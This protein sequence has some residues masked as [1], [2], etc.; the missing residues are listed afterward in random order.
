LK[1]PKRLI[2]KELNARYAVCHA[3]RHIRPA[4]LPMGRLDEL[5]RRIEA[6]R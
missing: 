3:G 2:N 4:A 6:V 1:I 5:V